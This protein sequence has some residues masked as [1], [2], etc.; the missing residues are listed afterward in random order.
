MNSGGNQIVAEFSVDDKTVR[1]CLAILQSPDAARAR[2]A[3]EWSE[4]H[5]KVVL[6]QVAGQSN[7]TTEAA[8][9]RDALRSE[10][11][12]EA[13]NQYRL[14]AESYFTAKDRRDAASATFEAWRTLQS[15]ERAFA[16]T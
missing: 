1:H 9:E 14:N 15:N 2:A 11:Y 6:A 7:A 13:L 5:L 4:K 16:R 8:R 12:Q 10:A 3:Y